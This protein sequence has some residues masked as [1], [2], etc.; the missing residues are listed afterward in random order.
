MIHG[1][2]WVVSPLKTWTLLM[3]MFPNCTLCCI[4]KY[5]NPCMFGLPIVQVSHLIPA[6]LKGQ[7]LTHNGSHLNRLSVFKC[8]PRPILQTPTLCIQRSLH[9][10]Y[11]LL[12]GDGDGYE[13]SKTFDIVLLLFGLGL[14]SNPSN[15]R[16][17]VRAGQLVVWL[18]YGDAAVSRAGL[19][20]GPT[21]WSAARISHVNAQPFAR[22]LF[23]NL[24][25]AGSDRDGKG[26]GR[27]GGGGGGA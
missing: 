13:I 9:H 19:Q 18:W 1:L 12:I 6:A 24:T 26:R 10:R 2:S 16:E 15:I 11:S 7:Q 5:A 4:K 21:S 23:Q 17:L 22:H 14:L 27:G 25:L 3:Y 8:I 20:K